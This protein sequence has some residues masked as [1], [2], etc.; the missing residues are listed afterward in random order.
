MLYY[1]LQHGMVKWG[2][3]PA[4]HE[5]AGEGKLWSKSMSKQAG[6]VR[7]CVAAN[8]WVACSICMLQSVRSKLAACTA[9]IALPCQSP[10]MSSS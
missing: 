9:G 2:R 6:L 1:V 8:D 4:V 7:T 5:E 3:L 10:G